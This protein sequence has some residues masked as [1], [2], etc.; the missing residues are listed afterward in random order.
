M[1][2]KDLKILGINPNYVYNTACFPEISFVGDSW[3]NN[4]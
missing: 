3:E 2:E 4:L 1:C